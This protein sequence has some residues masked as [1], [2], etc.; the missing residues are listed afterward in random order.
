MRW[1]MILPLK[2]LDVWK[3]TYL[4]RTGVSANDVFRPRIEN[5]KKY[6]LVAEN[7]D[8]IELTTLGSF[9]ADEVV[10]GFAAPDHIPFPRNAYRDGPLN[11]YVDN[12]PY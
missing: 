5:L 8:K 6:G 3:P 9:F 10:E 4:E 7:E 11:P 12:S 1:A 2:N